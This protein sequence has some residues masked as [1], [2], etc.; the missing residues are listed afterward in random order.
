MADGISWEL[1]TAPFKEMQADIAATQDRATMYAMRRVGAAIRTAAKA[2]A[3]VYSGSDPRASAESGNLRKS[4]KASRSITRLGAGNFSMTVGPFGTKKAG[5]AVRRHGTSKG[6]AR[7]VP[8][9]RRKM[10][11]RYGYMQAGIDAAEATGAA[12]YEAAYAKAWAKYR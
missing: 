8:L 2:K 3:P 1:I 10:E 5:T 6:Q 12:I 4:I 9:Y 7:G 11:D